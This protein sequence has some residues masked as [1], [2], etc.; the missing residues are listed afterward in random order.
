MNREAISEN[1]SPPAE[2]PRVRR[3][4]L[5]ISNLLRGGVV[6]SLTF[7]LFGTALSFLHHPAYLSSSAELSHLTQPG[8]AFPHTLGTVANGVRHLN[9]QALV[10]F[11]LMLLI[12]TPIMRVAVSIFAFIYQEDRVYTFITLMVLGLLL[13]SFVLGRAE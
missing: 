1:T 2:D 6:A 10:I 8:S 7:I 4:E 5:W 3:V 11:G 9:G 13:L 12:A